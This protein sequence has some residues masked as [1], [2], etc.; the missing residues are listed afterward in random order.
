MVL[1]K[2]IGKLKINWSEKK[3]GKTKKKKEKIWGNWEKKRKN[4]GK[5]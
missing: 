5:I 3:F 2:K 1:Q 4:W